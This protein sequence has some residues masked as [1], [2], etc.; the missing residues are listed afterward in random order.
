MRH[1]AL[2][3]LAVGLL[4]LALGGLVYVADRDPVQHMLR[5]AGDTTPHGTL[6][7]A[8]G[9]SLPSFAHALAFSLIAASFPTPVAGPR[10]GA[11]AFWCVVNLAFELGQHPMLSH[12]LSVA[13]RDASDALPAARS[14]FEALSVY[15]LRGTFDAGD[16]AATF[17][18]AAAAACLLWWNQPG[19]AGRPP[20]IAG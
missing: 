9:G 18:G 14:G 17:A 5:L 1:C 19:Q 7:G 3:P 11:C 10:Y 8:A 15:F 20:R 12:P 13:L 2:L 6:F 4:A 16:I